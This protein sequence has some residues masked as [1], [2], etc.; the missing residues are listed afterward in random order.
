MNDSEKEFL[1]NYDKNKYEKPSVT[2]DIIVLTTDK[3][4]TVL[5][6]LLVKRKNHPFKD[7]WAIPGGFVDIE[8]NLEDAAR[9]EL[10]EETG[11]ETPFI[12][13]LYTFGS[14]NRDPRMRVI[15]VAYMS[16]IPNYLLSNAVAGDDASEAE[17]FNIKVINRELET[18]VLENDNTHEIININSLAFDHSD[19]LKMA[20][21]R[22]KNKVEYTDIAFNLLPDNFTLFQIQKV[23][24]LLLQRQVVKQNF[25]RDIKKMLLENEGIKIDG[26]GPS[27]QS[28][29]LNRTQ[30]TQRY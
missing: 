2:T 28:Y 14:V 11:V 25:R 23:Y 26:I 27:A 20:L 22:I 12:E 5:K 9:R 19:V 4:Y 1:A 15:S 16:L 21:N 17:W 7:A 24:E 30:K 8:E 6:V 18:Y 3:N 10:K 29:R 13:Q